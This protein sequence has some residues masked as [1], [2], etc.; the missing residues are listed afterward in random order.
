V[1]WENKRRRRPARGERALAS[2]QAQNR[3]G[4]SRFRVRS[5]SSRE[6]RARD[7]RIGIYP[8]LL[9]ILYCHCYIY[10]HRQSEWYLTRSI[11]SCPVE[12]IRRAMAIQ[13][14]LLPFGCGSVT[15]HTMEL[16]GMTLYFGAARQPVGYMR[17]TDGRSIYDVELEKMGVTRGI[18]R[19]K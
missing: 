14:T 10:V 16:D 4:G 18:E 17:S 8:Q 6:A 11:A 9:I 13:S 1:Y 15:T 3:L 12:T 19:D 5:P 7:N 2:F